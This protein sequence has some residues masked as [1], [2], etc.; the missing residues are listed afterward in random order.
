MCVHVGVTGGA[1]DRPSTL[2]YKTLYSSLRQIRMEL[3]SGPLG[4]LL[5]TGPL[6]IPGAGAASV[7]R[8]L[9]TVQVCVVGNL[10][11]FR[12]VLPLRT[13]TLFY[14]TLMLRITVRTCTGT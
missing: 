12:F 3:E 5:S 11:E 10:S 2:V 4:R 14:Q 1:D 13:H 8:S 9:V 7:P 6:E